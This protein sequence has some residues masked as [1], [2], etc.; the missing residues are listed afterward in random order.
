LAHYGDYQNEIYFGGLSGRRP[1]F[2][3]RFDELEAK[4]HAALSPSLVSYVAGGCGNERTQDANVAAFDRWGLIPRMFVGAK[5][6]DLSIELFGMKLPSPLF[7]SPV[8]VIGLC[9]PRHAPRHSSACQ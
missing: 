3:I 5:Q 2:P 7:L 8:G 1:S 9:A 4:A 6:R